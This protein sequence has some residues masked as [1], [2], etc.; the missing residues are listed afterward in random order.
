MC[1]ALRKNTALFKLNGG[2]DVRVINCSS[3]RLT[4]RGN[5]GDHC[6]RVEFNT[7]LAND[8]KP[9]GFE[10]VG[11]VVRERQFFTKRNGIRCLAPIVIVGNRLNRKENGWPKVTG[12]VSQHFIQSL[13]V[14]VF[15]D[16]AIGNEQRI[17][18]S[19]F[20]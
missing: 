18:F 7:S 4:C 2:G 6:P 10:K 9:V 17:R 19:V 5:R 3:Q 1:L 14:K 12:N 11:I 20:K 16:S 15:E 8:L 13:T